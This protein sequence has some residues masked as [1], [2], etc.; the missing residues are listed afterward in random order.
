MSKILHDGQD[1]P[2]HTATAT[3]QEGR[4]QIMFELQFGDLETMEA[5]NTGIDNIE[6]TEGASEDKGKDV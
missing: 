5:A 4:F 3:V 2:W 1:V 6:L